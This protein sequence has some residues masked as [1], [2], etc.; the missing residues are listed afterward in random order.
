LL[1]I[2]EQQGC[3]ILDLSNPASP[4][5][6]ST[7]FDG[8]IGGCNHPLFV[9]K[10]VYADEYSGGLGIYD[11]SETGGPVIEANLYGGGQGSS[12]IYDMLFQSPY[13]Y[14]AASTDI[15]ETLN[16]YDTSATPATRVGQYFDP[17]QEAFAVQSSGNYVYVGGSSN[18]TVLDVTQPT[19][20]TL[21]TN[22]SVSAISLARS[23][24]TLFA[25]TSNNQLSILDLTNPAL[26]T[27]VSTL[28]L[29]DLPIHLR[30][31]GNLLLIADNLAGL[32][33]YNITTPHSPVLLSKVTDIAL[34]ADVAVVNQTAFVAADTDGLAIFDI[35]NPAAPLLLSK[36]S[37][38]RI[39]P[40]Y[41][42]NPLNEALSVAANN[43]LIYVGTL[44]DNGIVFGFDYSIL[45]VPRLVSIYA[46]GE[47]VETS[48]VAMLFSGS[49]IF[50]GGLLGFTE[51]FTEANISQ[52]YDS[53]ERDFPPLALQSI[54]P[55]GQAPQSATGAR[56][57]AHPDGA[58]FP[59]SVPAPALPG[60][61]TISRFRGHGDQIAPA[62]R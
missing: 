6:V 18:T 57:G 44:D 9:G 22:V 16:V 61:K 28:S 5:I 60:T 33:I 14:G 58:R 23:N 12:A 34:A 38:S 54:P 55:V 20:P 39:D 30:V 37:L 1:A 27:V 47:F 8:V 35:S 36:T 42:D 15:G 25:G 29:P 13:V 56:L 43:G 40:F 7:L 2:T 17:S 50:V 21:V 62:T 10:Y 45:A 24:N 32:M 48:V 49:N 31:T 52:P 3:L 41:N 4:Q 19:S 11:G 46:Y 51:S 53:I 59:K 26:P